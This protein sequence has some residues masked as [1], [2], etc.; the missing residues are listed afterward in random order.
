MNTTEYYAAKREI[1][2]AQLAVHSLQRREAPTPEV[3][4][5]KIRLRTARESMEALLR[6]ATPEEREQVSIGSAIIRGRD[7]K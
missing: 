7:A 5:A 6:D 1:E 4:A 3:D 2:N